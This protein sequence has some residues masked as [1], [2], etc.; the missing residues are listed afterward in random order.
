MQRH[1]VGRT[2]ASQAGDRLLL[3]LTA[4]TAPVILGSLAGRGEARAAARAPAPDATGQ[5]AST[6][7][8]AQPLDVID[9]DLSDLLATEVGVGAVG[10]TTLREVPAVVEVMTADQIRSL[11]VRDLRELMLYLTGVYERGLG[12]VPAEFHTLRIGGG[13][14]AGRILLV[15]DEHMQIDEFFE[16]LRPYH[17]PVG[18][19]ERVELLRGPASVLYGSGAMQAVVR[20]VTKRGTRDLVGGT[21]LVDPVGQGTDVAGH[22]SQVLALFGDPLRL[23]VDVQARQSEKRYAETRTDLEASTRHNLRVRNVASLATLSYRGFY[24]RLQQER[25]RASTLGLVGAPEPRAGRS[26]T[27]LYAAEA[28][29]DAEGPRARLQARL[30]AEYRPRRVALGLLPPFAFAGREA[31]ENASDVLMDTL[32]VHADALG[33][34]RFH[35]AT[36][37]VGLSFRHVQSSSLSIRYRNDDTPHVL[38]LPPGLQGGFDEGSGFVT[39]S[40]RLN[41]ALT[42]QAGGRL[43]LF[44]PWVRHYGAMF[45]DEEARPRL[46][47][48]PVGQLAIVWHPA[49]RSVVKLLLGRSYRNP[50]MMELFGSIGSL[51]RSDPNLRAETQNTL[52]AVID[53]VVSSDLALRL[54]GFYGAN[55][56]AIQIV[57]SGAFTVDSVNLSVDVVTYGA[58]ASLRW[59]L[60]PGIDLSASATVQSTRVDGPDDHDLEEATPRY[61]GSLRLLMQPFDSHGVRVLPS[62]RLRGPQSGGPTDAV[63]D[64]AVTWNVC[65]RV[66]LMLAGR[67]LLDRHVHFPHDGSSISGYVRRSRALRMAISAEL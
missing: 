65:P 26:H 61:L 64:L 31:H 53:T 60:R 40:V 57:S 32:A 20:V 21:M 47:T 50:T 9:L 55:S 16:S 48:Y 66:T 19:I 36:A 7:A 39:G 6:A 62:I 3:A 14:A 45:T 59:Q 58:N 56:D 1:H 23:R 34:R 42:V 67:N 30:G 44:R 12:M 33:M 41:D 51:A 46:S 29:Y 52:S 4:A 22:A 54:D 10:A 28:G 17:I 5:Q 63:I 37:S 15:V 18:C 24:L 11:G 38:G 35:G 8:E 43:N 27:A 25:L 49:D 13:P 2:F